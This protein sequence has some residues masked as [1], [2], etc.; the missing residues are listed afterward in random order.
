MS[1]VTL[2]LCGPHIAVSKVHVPL[3][4]LRN[5]HVALSIIGV[6][7]HKSEGFC[8]S[9][10]AAAAAAGVQWRWRCVYGGETLTGV[11]QL[12]S[13][14]IHPTPSSIGIHHWHT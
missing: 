9:R 8:A 6:Q 5:G 10:P 7:G 13:S 1:H 4:N 14:H 11:G 3:S 12:C 2:Y